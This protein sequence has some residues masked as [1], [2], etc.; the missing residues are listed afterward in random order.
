MVDNLSWNSHRRER[1]KEVYL[2]WL[3]DIH[4]PLLAVPKFGRSTA[5]PTER[6][7]DEQRRGKLIPRAQVAPDNAISIQ[8]VA[9]ETT[10]T[11]NAVCK[12][13]AKV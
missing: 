2:E 13:S 4:D 12:F 10:E 9:L 8:L 6:R 3:S 5:M 1:Q 11:F 7:E